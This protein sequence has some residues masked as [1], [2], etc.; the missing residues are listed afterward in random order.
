[1]LEQAC[2]EDPEKV[3]YI[4]EETIDAFNNYL[5]SDPKEALEI[6]RLLST[7]HQMVMEV[8]R[9]HAFLHWVN[10]LDEIR[11]AITLSPEKAS[12]STL[13]QLIYMPLN[14]DV[15]WQHMQLKARESCELEMMVL[16]GKY[17][18]SISYTLALAYQQFKE[19]VEWKKLKNV[20]PEDL[21]LSWAEKALSY[22]PQEI[23]RMDLHE[24][25]EFF[26]RIGSSR[27][28][29]DFLLKTISLY[30]RLLKASSD[31]A[32]EVSQI[33]G[34]WKEIAEIN[35]RN[36]EKVKADKALA[37]A[38]A[39]YRKHFDQVKSNPSTYL[40]YAEFLEYC[41]FTYDGTINKP[42]L[43]ELKDVTDEVEIQSKGFLSYP[44]VLLMRIALFQND[45]KQAILE[46]TKSLILHECCISSTIDN[47]LEEF[48][49]SN[50]KEVYTFLNETK[51]FMEEVSKNYYYDP[52][53]S[54]KQLRT[55]S[56]EELKVYWENRKD[57]IRNRISFLD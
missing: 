1:M 29:V 23:T 22:N 43:S 57:E 34:I 3:P 38:Q 21:A 19:Y 49:N 35:L 28:R 7:A 5:L 32:L 12:W 41:S 4:L 37:E 25:I 48:K 54:W 39:I 9:R 27:M 2:K 30:E 15:E 53:L 55:M 51:L 52:A 40:R 36:Q 24:C 13:L 47:L 42:S 10:A 18:S 20:F 45:E 56:A 31:F 14:D 26:H 17:G 11:K 33:V 46:L 6:H 8:D 50:Y 16:E 44:Y